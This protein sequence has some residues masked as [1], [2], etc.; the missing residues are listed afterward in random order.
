[1]PFKM[2]LM[3]FWFINNEMIYLKYPSLLL[4]ICFYL[5]MYLFDIYPTPQPD[6]D[7]WA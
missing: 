6:I 3:L 1:M 5:A 7:N 4:L 2:F